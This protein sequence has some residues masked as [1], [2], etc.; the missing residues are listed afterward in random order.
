MRHLVGR[1]RPQCPVRL[2]R[3]EVRGGSDSP[4]S[5]FGAEQEQPYS[6]DYDFVE[7]SFVDEPRPIRDF[8]DGH[9]YSGSYLD[10]VARKAAEAGITEANVSV[11][12]DKGQFESPRSATGP[13][14]ELWYLGEFTCRE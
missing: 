11:L 4:P 14:Y 13:G 7:I 10:A 3:T 1:V 6:F 8:V 5:Q 12:A 2:L 9:S